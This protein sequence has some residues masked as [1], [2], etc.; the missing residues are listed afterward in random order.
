M[1]KGTQRVP[2]FLFLLCL[3]DLLLFGIGND[4][5][6]SLPVDIDDLY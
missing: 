3:F 2:F 5:F 1:K 6:V 4:E